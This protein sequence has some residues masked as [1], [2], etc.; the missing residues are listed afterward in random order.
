[1][2]LPE[3]RRFLPTSSI[4]RSNEQLIDALSTEEASDTAIPT[5]VSTKREGAEGP[6]TM[7]TTPDSCRRDRLASVP[8]PDCS[9]TRPCDPVPGTIVDT[10]S[11]Q[12][13]SNDRDTS[14]H[15]EGPVQGSEEESVAVRGGVGDGKP[16]DDEKRPF[17][18]V[19]DNPEEGE[20][21][22]SVD[23]S[24][25]K[26]SIQEQM[27]AGGTDVLQETQLAESTAT[28]SLPPGPQLATL[29]DAD[30]ADDAGDAGN[31]RDGNKE[32]VNV[33]D[34]FSR[35]PPNE[36]SVYDASTTSS[37]VFSANAIIR[38][39][40]NFVTRKLIS[41][42]APA[43]PPVTASPT[44]VDAGSTLRGKLKSSGFPPSVN[45]S[46]TAESKTYGRSVPGNAGTTSQTGAELSDKQG[47]DSSVVADDN[48]TERRSGE[49][50]NEEQRH[51]EQGNTASQMTRVSPSVMEVSFCSCE[52]LN[53]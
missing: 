18:A 12:E 9:L 16:V 33:V 40:V 21:L 30:D 35:P 49:K 11:A 22:A 51:I 3:P 24:E 8:E 53:L 39:D 38:T 37:S 52:C 7:A 48:Q 46:K 45:I 10:P 13:E 34:T 14:I 27:R 15:G 4:D 5:V 19:S 2:L 25:Q 20:T 32:R 26:R 50:G 29:D 36:L 1:M 31:K 47:S 6:G 23:C 41:S 42:G 17:T 28:P 44:A 43:V